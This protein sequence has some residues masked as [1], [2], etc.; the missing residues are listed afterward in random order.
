MQM[1]EDMDTQYEPSKEPHEDAAFQEPPEE[2]K[3]A[4]SESAPGPDRNERLWGM[5]CHLSGAAFVT[6][7]PFANVLA[8]F[9]IWMLKREN[10]PFVDTE[11]EEAVNFQITMSIGLLIGF[12]LASIHPVFGIVLIA[13]A[14]VDLVFVLIASTKT[15]VG[16]SYRYPL[17]FRFFK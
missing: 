5:A 10:R 4:V 15:N 16:E 12:L 3:P 13:V 7:I 17:A 6:F 14:I 9:V 1:P 2:E 8:P 11:G